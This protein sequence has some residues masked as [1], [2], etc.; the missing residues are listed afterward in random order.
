MHHARET[1]NLVP[2]EASR[3]MLAVTMQERCE[4]LKDT[5]AKFDRGVS[6]YSGIACI[7]ARETKNRWRTWLA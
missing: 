4:I 3:V 7:N 6:E 2:S 5:G 1:R